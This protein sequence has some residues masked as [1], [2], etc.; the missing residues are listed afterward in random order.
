MPRH[1]VTNQSCEWAT[2]Q[3]A[4]IDY[5]I[6]KI[7]KPLRFQYGA[8]RYEYGF[9]RI[10]HQ[11]VGKRTRKVRCYAIQYDLTTDPLRSSTGKYE[12]ERSATKQWKLQRTGT[13][14]KERTTIE[15]LR[16][17][18]LVFGKISTSL[19]LQ[20]IHVKPISPFPCNDFVGIDF[21]V[22]FNVLISR[23]SYPHYIVKANASENYR[24]N[25]VWSLWQNRH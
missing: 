25:R 4:T 13:N 16:P 2:I 23:I 6:V 3:S 10:Y 20:I 5:E 17:Q 7:R 18:P 12:L 14:R 8:Q 15:H 11:N 21:L 22:Q 19:N 24:F 1:T 9:R